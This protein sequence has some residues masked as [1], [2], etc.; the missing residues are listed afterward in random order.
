MSW[1]NLAVLPPPEHPGH[2]DL[3]RQAHQEED[4]SGLELAQ[5][6]YHGRGVPRMREAPQEL[7]AGE[8][9]SEKISRDSLH[10]K[11]SREISWTLLVHLG[12]KAVNRETVSKQ[13][14]V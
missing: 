7:L 4:A 2:G 11:G 1:T 5:V 10:F 9:L 3:R 8:F 6:P 13:K 14:G 12:R